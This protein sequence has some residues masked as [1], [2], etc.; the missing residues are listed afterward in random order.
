MRGMLRRGLRRVGEG[1]L[2]VRVWSHDRDFG[3]D[4]RDAVVSQL[5]LC[6]CVYV[7]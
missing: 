3:S 5:C 4:S 7:M 6:K 2:E 1:V